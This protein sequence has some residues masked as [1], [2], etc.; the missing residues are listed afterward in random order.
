MSLPGHK[1]SAEY[2]NPSHISGGPDL[3]TSQSHSQELTGSGKTIKAHLPGRCDTATRQVKS[4][5]LSGHWCPGVQGQW[6]IFASRGRHRSCQ[7]IQMLPPTHSTVLPSPPRWLMLCSLPSTAQCL[8]GI[9]NKAQ[10]CG[11]GCP[12]EIC[13]QHVEDSEVP[14][15]YSPLWL[16]LSTKE[17]GNS[18]TRGVLS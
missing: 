3:F 9:R 18:W 2:P 7:L 4:G 11:L 6:W 12:G 13:L 17:D 14:G 8:P 10:E 16:Y 1:T 5:I 15:I